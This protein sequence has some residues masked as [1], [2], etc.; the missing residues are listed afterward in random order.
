MFLGLVVLTLLAM[1]FFGP[2][3]TMESESGVVERIEDPTVAGPPEIVSEEDEEAAQGEDAVEEEEAAPTPPDDPTMYLSVP[4]LG[5]SN[6]IVLDGE[7]GLEAG[8]QHLEGTGYPWLPG[9]NTYLAGHRVGFPG[10]G[11]DHI[12]YALPSMALGDEISLQDSLGQVY[13]YRVSNIFA[14]TPYDVW[15][16]EPTGKDIVSLQVCTE[17]PDD[18]WTIGPRLMSSGPESGRLIVQAEKV[19]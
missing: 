12:F 7:V 11:S 9:S 18:W 16:A 15:V 10:T 3:G 13:T 17:T 19:A 1:I 8:V 5:I 14:V 6:S 2:D 4:K